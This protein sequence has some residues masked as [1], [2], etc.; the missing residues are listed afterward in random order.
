MS[1]E[2]YVTKHYTQRT[3]PN[4]HT[5]TPSPSSQIA[6]EIMLTTELTTAFKKLR[7]EQVRLKLKATVSLP[8]NS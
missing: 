2:E 6:T 7:T 8:S 4:T 5:H 3:L 1:L